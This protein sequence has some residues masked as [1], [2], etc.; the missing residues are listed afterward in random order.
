MKFDFFFIFGTQLQIL[1]ALGEVDDDFV[2]NAAMVPIAIVALILAARFCRREKMKSMAI[3][4]V[5][6]TFKTF[7]R[8]DLTW[9]QVCMCG[10]TASLIKT[11]GRTESSSNSDGLNSYRVSLTLFA[12]IAIL[13]IVCTLVNSLLCILNFRKG[14]KDHIDHFR[15]KRP[16]PD[17]VGL[18]SQGNESRFV[19]N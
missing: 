2:V 15:G 18:R 12:A 6:T 3:P 10:I 19:L 7:F 13:L 8:S 14:L 16:D 11:L 4:I 5:R 9:S 1:L 17:E